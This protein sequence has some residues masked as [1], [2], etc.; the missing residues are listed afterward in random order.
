LGEPFRGHTDS[1]WSVSFSPDGTR[2]VFGSQDSAVR[3]LNAATGQQFQEH[4]EFHSPAVHVSL[5]ADGWMVGPDRRLLFWVPPASR[6]QPLYYP[7]TVWVIPNGL[8]LD[9][10]RMAH[11]EQWWKC[12]DA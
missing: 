9:L 1:V 3:L 12:R 10:S 11:G 6:Q 2:I 4:T 5:E 7:G 8:E